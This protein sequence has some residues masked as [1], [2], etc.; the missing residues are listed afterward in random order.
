MYILHIA[1]KTA[2]ASPAH[3]TVQL[4]SS[5]CSRHQRALTSQLMPSNDVI[6]RST[7]YCTRCGGRSDKPQNE[8]IIDNKILPSTQP[9]MCSNVV[10]DL[11][12]WTRFGWNRCSSWI[13]SFSMLCSYCFM[14]H[15]RQSGLVYDWTVRRD[16][17]R[18][19]RLILNIL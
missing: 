4:Q 3:W 15:H 11:S 6:R 14:T 8:A 7:G 16:R 17:W 18:N 10:V 19:H 2:T 1:L 9:T 13:C 12:R 5:T